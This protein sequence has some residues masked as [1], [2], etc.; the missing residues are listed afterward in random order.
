[1]RKNSHTFLEFTLEK[2]DEKHK[3]AFSNMTVDVDEQKKP[4]VNG[5]G[6]QQ[7]ME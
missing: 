7:T 4:P 5:A 2:M 3:L 1:M 6:C